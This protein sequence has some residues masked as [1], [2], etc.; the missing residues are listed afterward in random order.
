MSKEIQYTKKQ[1][2]QM[3][4]YAEHCMM[5]LL[6]TYPNGEDDMGEIS[7]YDLYRIK[8]ILNQNKDENIP[9]KK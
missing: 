8:Q 4:S 2:K 9:T 6:T 3:K 5:K 1:K 7:S